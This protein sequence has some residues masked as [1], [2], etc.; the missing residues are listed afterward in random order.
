MPMDKKSGY[1]SMKKKPVVK[2]AK[3]KVKKKK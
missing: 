2:K 3:P 1:G